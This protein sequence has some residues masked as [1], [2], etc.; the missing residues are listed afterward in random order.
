MIIEAKHVSV[1]RETKY[2][3]KDINWSVGDGEHWAILGLNGS[4]KTTL[5]DMLNGYTFPSKGEISVLGQTFGRYDWRELRKSI[6]WVSTALQ[7]RLYVSETVEDIVLSGKFAS[8]GLYEN[9]DSE[10]RDFARGL[11]SRLGCLELYGRIYQ[12][13]SQGEKQRVLIA[14]GLMSSPK[15]LILDEP[16]TGLDI[17]AKEKLLSIIEKLSSEQD[18]PT[19]I[20]VTHLTEE[21]L[22]TFSH[23]LLLRRGEVHSAGETVSILTEDNLSDFFEAPVRCKKSGD[24][25][26]CG[27]SHEK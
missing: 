15:L 2:I 19:I 11:L 13:L 24:R 20:Y 5:L 3:L 17:F 9:T 25:L 10:D 7:E 16:C 4:G 14:R 12:T 18:A 26:I 22:P 23:T 21:I 8:I 1:I 27:L 6:G